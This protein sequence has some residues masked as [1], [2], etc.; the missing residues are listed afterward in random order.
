MAMTKI[1]RITALYESK[2]REVTGSHE[3]W[4]AF[5]RSACRNYKCPFDE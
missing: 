1:E 5:L 4:T 3:T 2:I